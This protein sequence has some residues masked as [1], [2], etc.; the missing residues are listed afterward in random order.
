VKKGIDWRRKIF[1]RGVAEENQETP[2]L[3]SR[4]KVLFQDLFLQKEK[5]GE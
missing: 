4:K 1:F 3:K 2:T 5:H